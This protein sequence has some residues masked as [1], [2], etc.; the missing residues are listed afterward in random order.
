M[1]NILFILVISATLITCGNQYQLSRSYIGKSVTV[2]NDDFGKPVH[3]R[4]NN[5]DS[6]LTFERTQ[7]LRS[8]EISQGKT[9]LDPIYTPSV[10]KTTLFHFTVQN[11][12]ITG[13]RSEEDYERK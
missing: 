3:V 6:V 11:G 2:L 13:I 7:T 1:K 10:V 12:I 5:N 9:S 4:Q 8:T